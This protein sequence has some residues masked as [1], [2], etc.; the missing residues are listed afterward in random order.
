MLGQS[1]GIYDFPDRNFMFNPFV[2]LVTLDARGF[3][4]FFTAKPLSVSSF[5]AKKEKILAPRA[6]A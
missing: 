3:F 2:F 1:T 6:F 5:A 4:F